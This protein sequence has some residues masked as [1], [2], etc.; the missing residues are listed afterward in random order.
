M[1]LNGSVAVVT[2]GGTGIGAAV[3]EGL[4]RAGASAVLVGYT[5]S[6]DEARS[7]VE[8]LCAAGAVGS[9]AVAMDVTDDDA[10][11]AVAR[12]VVARH[13]RV[14]VLV[15]NAG[16]TVAVPFEDLEGATDAIWH[17]VLDVNLVGA[18]R[19]ARALGPA[20]RTAGGAVVNVA[21]ISAY[22]A[23]GSSIVYGVSKAALLQLTR[24]LARALAPEV[25]VNAV[26]PGTVATRWQTALHGQE[27]FDV[28]AAAERERAPLQRTVEPV[29][30]AQ[31]VLGLLGMDLVTGEDVVIDAGTWLRY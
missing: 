31:A 8:R 6:E 22:R 13:G 1:D 12:D 27:G 15:N 24:G 26:T 20:L 10:V 29:H 11:R 14:D 17:D 18:Y 19:C 3:A 16:A 4:A 21:S 30:V 28:L 5:R 9:E 7:V 23:L 2:G 25:R